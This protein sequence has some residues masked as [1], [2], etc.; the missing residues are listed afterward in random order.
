M[1]RLI[2]LALF[3]LSLAACGVD[4]APTRPKDTKPQTPATS[5]TITLSGQAKIGIAGGNG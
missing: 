1:T 4:G 3:S 2:V 5:G